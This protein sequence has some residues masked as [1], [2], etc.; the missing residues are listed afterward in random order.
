MNKQTFF[1]LTVILFIIS[2][3]PPAKM[4]RAKAYSGMYAEKPVTVLIMP[5]INKSTNID[6]KDYFHS[7]LNIPLANEGY[8]VIPPF[9][10]MEILKK[11]S[12]YDAELFLNEP[13]NKFGEVFGAD[14]VLFTIIH[15][16]DKTLLPIAHITVQIEY[17]IKSTKT[18]QVLYTRKAKVK[19]PTGVNTG[20][21]GGLGLIANLTLTAINTA[22]TTFVDVARQS[23]NITFLDMPRGKYSKNNLKDSSVTA[24]KK[25]FSY[26]IKQN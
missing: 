7:T 16:W 4:T 10:S 20:L 22:T 8:Y 24:G 3:A 12:A 26:T 9:L 25:E 15:R 17:I 14:M 5:P 2:C 21:G 23:N 6:A 11:E 19:Y 18:N 1:W 13:L